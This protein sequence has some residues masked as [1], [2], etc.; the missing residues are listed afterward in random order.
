MSEKGSSVTKRPC[1]RDYVP[2]AEKTYARAL[3]QYRK[4]VI[5]AIPSL[6]DI[7]KLSVVQIDSLLRERGASIHGSRVVKE[8]RL[9]E[10]LKGRPFTRG[11]RTRNTVDDPPEFATFKAPLPLAY[12]NGILEISVDVLQTYVFAPVR[13]DHEFLFMACTVCKTFYASAH[14][15][16]RMDAVKQFGPMGTPMALLERGR[17]LSGNY[18]FDLRGIARHFRLPL[19]RCRYIHYRTT[20]RTEIVDQIIALAIETHGSIDVIPKLDDIK[21][22]NAIAVQNE[23]AFIH[24]LVPNTILELNRLL[25]VKKLPMLQLEIH[26]TKANRLQWTNP[27]IKNCLFL[28]AGVSP[29]KYLMSYLRRNVFSGNSGERDISSFCKFLPERTPHILELVLSSNVHSAFPSRAYY[30]YTRECLHHLLYDESAKTLFGAELDTQILNVFDERC[31][32]S[33][34]PTDYISKLVVVVWVPGHVPVLHAYEHN[35][36]DDEILCRVRLWA[37][38]WKMEFSIHKTNRS[39]LRHC[40]GVP[41]F[42]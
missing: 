27:Y 2:G 26:P 1:L 32:R 5:S 11:K 14:I 38:D 28:I 41:S 39:Q 40:H 37:R 10:V 36:I 16:L 9:G 24:S 21:A 31:Y 30:N 19:N 25:E 7:H 22:E 15:L 34:L 6:E 42:K 17:F 33:V 13:E 35:M 12:G 29:V 3:K 18:M 20:D 8:Y 4:S 23:T